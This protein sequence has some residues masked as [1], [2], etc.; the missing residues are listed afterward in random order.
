MNLSHLITAVTY[1][2]SKITY[3]T[4]QCSLCGSLQTK[5][6]WQSK[7]V[8]TS[9]KNDTRNISFMNINLYRSTNP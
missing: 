9:K 7:N 8:Y 1:S 5:I 2:Y 4:L 6:R 3:N